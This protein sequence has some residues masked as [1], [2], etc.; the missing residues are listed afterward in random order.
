MR[1]LIAK[2]ETF[3]ENHKLL[4]DTVFVVVMSIFF[5]IGWVITPA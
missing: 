5:I 1:K 2:L 3:E 4:C